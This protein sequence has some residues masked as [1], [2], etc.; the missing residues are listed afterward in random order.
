[1][2]GGLGLGILYV[3]I[4]NISFAINTVS[5]RRGMLS[6]SAWQGVYLSVLIGTPIFLISALVSAQI[7]HWAEIG[8]F[9][10]GILGLA[11]VLHFLFGRYCNYRTLGI[12][13][14]NRANPIVQSNALFSVALAIPLLGESVTPLM[15]GGIA[16]LMLAPSFSSPNRRKTVSTV[17]QETR[18]TSQG[19]GTE[20]S[21]NDKPSS[22]ASAVDELSTPKIIEGYFFGI[23]NSIAWGASSL[24]IRYGLQDS[25]GLGV[26]G[27]LIAYSAASLV[28]LPTLLNRTLRRDLWNMDRTAGKWF[29]SSTITVS[30][31]QL[32]RFMALSVAPVVIVVPLLRAGGVLV[33]P[34]SYFINRKIESFEPRVLIA[35]ALSLAGALLLVL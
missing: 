12:L 27:A 26:L 33:V 2:L 24:L 18:A 5:A 7:F 19:N 15:W 10:Y 32:F 23:L 9:K 17:A 31:A 35:I 4:S 1:M 20:H 11:G 21:R 3:A 34:M 16:L 6:G 29:L 25:D 22:Y 14:A 28:L 30:M 13:G 8:P